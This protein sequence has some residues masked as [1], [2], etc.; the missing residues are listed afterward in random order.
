MSSDEDLYEDSGNE[1][2]DIDDDHDD[3]EFGSDIGLGEEPGPSDRH[4]GGHDDDFSYE[5]LST[6]QIVQHMVDCI[7]E[8]TNVIQVSPVIPSSYSTITNSNP[9]YR[10]LRSGYCSTTSNGTKKS[11][12]SVIL[13]MSKRKCF[14]KQRSSHLTK[15]Q[16]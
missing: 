3:D 6:E 1:S 12:W 2:P 16:P 9:R 14:K 11:S 10:P 13:E 8:V 5:V 4:D 7:S 15:K